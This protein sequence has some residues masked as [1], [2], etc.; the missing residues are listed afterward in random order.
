MNLSA[1]KRRER[2]AVL[3]VAGAEVGPAG[4]EQDGEVAPAQ[5]TE[6]ADGGAKSGEAED[7]TDGANLEQ[8]SQCLIQPPTQHPYFLLLLGCDKQVGQ[9]ALWDAG[10]QGAEAQQGALCCGEQSGGQ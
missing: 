8:L 4:E 10:L 1:R 5:E 3:S 2:K 9:G 6:P 7:S